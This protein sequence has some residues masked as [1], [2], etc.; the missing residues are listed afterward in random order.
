MTYQDYVGWLLKGIVSHSDAPE[1]YK[2]NEYISFQGWISK[3][4][5]ILQFYTQNLVSHI[6]H[7]KSG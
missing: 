2:N 5:S 7:E 6:K 3:V 1:I 4:M